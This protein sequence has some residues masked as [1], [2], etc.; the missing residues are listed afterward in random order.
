MDE[1]LENLV[2][3]FSADVSEYTEGM[4]EAVDVTEDTAE[5]VE[6]SAD[7]VRGFSESIE[8]FAGAATSALAAIG[9]GGGLSEALGNFQE[10][11]LI[12]LRLTAT[13]EA[14]GRQVQETMARYE[15]FALRMEGATTAE[16][17][18]VLSLLSTAESFGLTGN[19]AEKATQDA[20][21]FASLTGGSAEAMMR[22]T[23]AMQK[24]D[25]GQAQRF[26][27]MI[28][29]LRGIRDE[30]QF[31]ARYQELAALGFRLAGKEAESSSGSFTTLMRD[32]GNMTE[33]FGDFV[34]Q[35]V[36]PFVDGLKVIIAWVRALSPEIKALITV[37]LSLVTGFLM[38][39]PI[40][41]AWGA[42]AS[43]MATLGPILLAVLNPLRLIMILFGAF[44]GLIS[45]IG[46][47]IAFVFSPLGLLIA[48]IV[49]VV[50]V[51]VSQLGGLSGTWEAI[52][53][54]AATAWAWIQERIMAFLDWAMPLF[55]ALG[56]LGQTVWRVIQDAVLGLW[57]VIVNVF[58]AVR[59]FVLSVW[60]TITGNTEADWGV[61]RD[62]IMDA[63]MFAEFTIKNFG[64]VAS[65][66]WAN[67][68]L[69]FVQMVGV[70]IH[71]FTTQIPAYLTWFGNNW[72]KIFTDVF[73]F[74]RTI[75]GNMWTNISR[76]FSN[77][78]NSLTGGDTD[79]RWTGLLDG[80]EATL[81]ELPEI[82]ER[83]L[84]PL[85]RQLQNE[86]DRQ[87]EALGQGWEEFRQQRLQDI[88]DAAA[89]PF[90]EMQDEEEE[91][92]APDTSAIQQ[93]TN[94]IEKF[95]AVLR[96]SA[97]SSARIAAYVERNR[98]PSPVGP[99][100]GQPAGFISPAGAAPGAAGVQGESAVTLLR[101][102]RDG[103]NQLVRVPQVEVEEVELGA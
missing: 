84:G 13:L 61:I 48:G 82:A 95:D 2:V 66:V 83:E 80:F 4:E 81:T 58:T 24:G 87:A 102:I 59:D 6:E 74:V 101:Q 15:A 43:A 33:G 16:D 69:G 35:I 91:V 67:I 53:S 27:R 75:F 45:G 90:R 96:N 41:A 20:L 89:L 8:G 34:A 29:Q 37:A 10:A 30:S 47:A 55:H 99:A 51:V 56:F 39:A 19:A 57:D 28:P 23:A 73:N 5:E 50:A 85:E 98:L 62:T 44:G 40:V 63:I 60:R 12:G 1:E 65:L 32:L 46:A 17:D 97:E 79:W 14:N 71:F 88:A 76:F 21:S 70:I 103:I 52:R 25:V 94:D 18:F 36:Q 49:A 77:V 100:A 78:W 92:P 42:L 22:L 38:I 68:K 3:R 64:A 7:K 54:A 31:V 86:V 72:A 26:A 93:A 11:E 9:L